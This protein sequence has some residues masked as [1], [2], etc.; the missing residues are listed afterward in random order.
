MKK[1]S[2]LISIG[3]ISGIVLAL[4]LKIVQL[5]TGN[6]IYY[7]LFDTSY[8]PIL[9]ELKPTWLVETIFHFT[10]CII[11]I[12]ALY[13]LLSFIR[14][15]KKIRIY[16]LVFGIGSGCLYFL[17]L[18]STKTPAASNLRAFLYWTIAHMLFSLTA[19]VLIKRFVKD[20]KKDRI[21]HKSDVN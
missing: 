3:I 9:K 5:V 13:Y 20:V 18:F 21:E 16:V 12:I 2:L 15:E 17:T 14:L 8:I 10:S 4:F 6:S 19:G 1:G 11:S 7:L